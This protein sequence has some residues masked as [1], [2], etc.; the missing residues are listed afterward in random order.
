MRQLAEA[1]RANTVKLRFFRGAVYDG[2]ADEYLTQLTKFIDAVVPILGVAQTPFHPDRTLPECMMPDGGDCCEGYQALLAE[3][4]RIT[5]ID[6]SIAKQLQRSMERNA[7]LVREIERLR[8]PAQAPPVPMMR[9][10]TPEEDARMRDALL[11]SGSQITYLEPGTKDAWQPIKTN[12][13]VSAKRYL[14]TEGNRLAIPFVGFRVY[15]DGPW[16]HDGGAQVYPTHWMDLPDT[17]SIS[18]S[19]LSST[20]QA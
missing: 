1:L 7:E 16:W 9:E 11:N 3:W 4:R 5:R 14:I 15:E 20:D 8:A 18:T 13:F 2:F 10:L 19:P 12:P 6:D 17:S